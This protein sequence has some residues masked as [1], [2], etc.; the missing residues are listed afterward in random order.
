MMKD[1]FGLAFGNLRKRGIRSWLTMLGI[2]IGIAAVVSLISLGQGLQ[3]AIT[4]QFATLDVDKLIVSNADTGFA[5]P[6]ATAVKKL[7]EHDLEL[8]EDVIG[9]EEVVPRIV[10]VVRV[11]YNEFLDFSFIANVPEEV[12]RRKIVYDA[13]NVDV[14]DG[15]LL[16]DGDKG[17]VLL[18]DNFR[19]NRFGKELRVGNKLLIEDEKFEV[20]GF[21][22]RASTFQI[23]SVILMLDSDLM[24]ILKLEDEIDIIVVKVAEG[25][26]TQEIAIRLEQEL[27]EERNLKAGEDDFSVQTPL[28]GIQGV[29]NVLTTINLIVAAIA[30]IALVVG[31]VG[32]TNT[33]F[34]SVVE[35][36]RE[37]GV[38]KSVG[39]KNKDILWIFLFESGLLG[40]VG[41]I[42]GSLLGL[43]LAFG[44]ATGAN[45]GLGTNLFQ[46]QIDYVLI[47]GAIIF[48]F[49]I[50]VLSGLVPAYQASKLNPVDA[51]RK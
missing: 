46:V 33:M 25:E 34:T 26:D 40:L 36:T 22:K 15:K 19:D 21:L 14:D 37:I 3:N 31:G 16:E 49:G 42:I 47:M 17:K 20:A 30:G 9:V 43:L 23:N 1:Y 18:G 8:I 50:G 28:Q 38:M 45:A 35:R 32:I 10:R 29:N 51:L 39:A 2:F 48:S 41:G 7:N 13:L 12:D 11:E 24:E 5:P 6:G 44:A 4:A 27:R